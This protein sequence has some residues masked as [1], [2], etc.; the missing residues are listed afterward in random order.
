[1]PGEEKDQERLRASIVDAKFVAWQQRKYPSADIAAQWEFFVE[2]CL[3]R[4]LT[5]VS[6]RHAF[7]SS[8][9]WENSPAGRA[10][11]SPRERQ[12]PEARQRAMQDWVKAKE[13]EEK[14]DP[15]RVI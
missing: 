12:S 7:M 1:M 8:F 15:D 11:E 14:H 2:R 5:Y 9:V 10:R 6:F 3:A 4:G 13:E